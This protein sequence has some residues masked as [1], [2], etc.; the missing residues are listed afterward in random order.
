LK[1]AD[2]ALQ[3]HTNLITQSHPLL[4]FFLQ[5][6]LQGMLW[7][8]GAGSCLRAAASGQLY[9]GSCL[10]AP[11]KEADQLLLPLVQVCN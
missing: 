6:W 3:A 1:T 4:Y 5:A 7:E 10:S 9:Q 11:Q 2:L 8:Q